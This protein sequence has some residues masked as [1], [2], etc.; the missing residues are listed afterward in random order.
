MRINVPS[1][2]VGVFLTVVLAAQPL[3]A[4]QTYQHPPREI[5]DVLDAPPP[6]TPLVSPAGNALIL[7][8]P[9][10]YRPISDLAEPMLRG[11]GTR[12]NPR[13]NG[14]HLFAYNVALKLQQI[15][16]GPE[17]PIALPAGARVTDP[18]WNAS[19]SL[20]AFTNVTATSVELWAGDAAGAKVHRVEGI[21]LNPALGY[22]LQ[23]MPD[24]KTLLI[25]T[26]PE[27]RG[28]PPSETGA[29]TGPRVEDSSGVK[30]ASSTYEAVEL[31]KTPYDREAFEYYTTT[32]LAMVDVL[33]GNITKIGSPAVIT[34]LV[35]S[36]DG[37]YLLVERLLTPY[38]SLRMFNRFAT[39]VEIW[40]ISGKKLET[41]ARQPLAEQVPVDGVR[42]GP[43]DHGWRPTAPA[44]VVWEEALDDGDTYKKVPYH[45]RVMLKPM[46][47][48]A[49]EL[50]RTE[51]RFDNINWI[52]R[53]GL[54]LVT[55][56]DYDKR[57][58]RTYL[59]DAD[60]R[61]AAPKVV[62]SQSLDDGYKNPGEP[63]LRRL[64]NGFNAVREFKGAIF[65]SGEGASPAGNRPF[66]DRV[67]LRTLKTERL[68]RS[69]PDSLESFV[70]W[71]NPATMTFLTR[72]ESI[73]D[74]PNVYLRSLGAALPANTVEGETHFRS[75]SRQITHFVDQATQLRRISK[76]LV[77]YQ[78][79]DGVKLSFT[80]YLPP[81]YQAGTRLPTIIWAYPLDYT[82][83]N[84]AGQVAGTAQNYTSVFGASP[85]F[86][87]LEGYAVL[88]ETAMPVVGPTETAYDT[89]ID[90][91]VANAKAA[92][93]KAVELGVTD[94]DRVGVMGH[95]H[96]ALMT[97][98]L[99]AWSD[100]FRAGVARSGA[101]NQTLRPFGF[102]NERRTLYKAPDTYL[103]LSPLVHAD[104]I[105]TP[106]LII[107]G[108]RDNNPG[109]VPL[110]SEKLF[111]AVRG[112]GGTV[113]L[114][115][116]PLEAHGYFA[117]ESVEHTLYETLTW[118]D[119][120]VKNA[121]PR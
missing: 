7:A 53:G 21:R 105:K 66:L 67:D 36:P 80:L 106:L 111:E 104:R 50:I 92:I 68:F 41:L 86:L 57:W 27:Q 16:D 20:F 62:W 54:A 89:F 98:N 75:T 46:G 42:V 77:T 90:Q 73:V 103:K 52:E 84:A 49:S 107:H 108:E 58:F 2:A 109:T 28:T 5:V 11:A 35:R 78:R 14:S 116:L 91:I 94:R 1:T 115:M 19:G 37:Q 22:A 17:V 43:R 56:V 32:Q 82:D 25:K 121:P 64:A 97:V 101:Y 71:I 12:I 114:V 96:G 117:R 13:N 60:N 93:D 65:T 59:V 88:D 30:S 24:Q 87:A 100:L 29:P 99:L 69:S 3:A 118:F 120:Y 48:T 113:R 63:V 112:V 45:D 79:P 18:R 102:Q 44:T 23:W 72:R 40:D 39:E 26:V 81:G 10:R 83:P 51:Q 15:P 95:S 9:V 70:D 38:S 33:S 34:K 76:R 85:I 8:T 119:R 47:G 4:Q 110:Q 61:S 31:L 55:E 74:P 6:P